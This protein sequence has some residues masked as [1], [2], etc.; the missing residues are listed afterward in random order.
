VTHPTRYEELGHFLRSRRERLAPAAV[1]LPAGARRR[2]RGLRREEVAVLAH[3]SP[4]WYAYLEQGRPVHP[5]AAVLDS[6]ADALLLGPTERRYLHA[7]GAPPSPAVQQRLDLPDGVVAEVGAVM[8]LSDATGHPAYAVDGRGRLLGW[9]GPATDWYDDFAA[10][11]Q[12]N[13]VRWLLTAPAARERIVDWESE[14]RDLTARVRFFVGT[15]AADEPARALVAEL[16]A[17]SAEFA[18]WWDEH[19]VSEQDSR[20]RTFRRPSGAVTTLRLVVLRLAVHP[21]VTVVLHAP[22]AARGAG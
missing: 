5:S 11:P 22:A 3:L 13:I 18:R 7:L 8:A 10:H 15:S 17:G 16:R 1:G 19:D 14:A 6:L 12:P 21:S 2:T 9:N 4:T 20:S